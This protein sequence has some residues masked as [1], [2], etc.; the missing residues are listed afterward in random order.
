MVHRG[1]SVVLHG[2]EL[3]AVR[4]EDTLVAT[5]RHK[6]TASAAPM[7]ESLATELKEAADLLASRAARLLGPHWVVAPLDTLA[8]LKATEATQQVERVAG[9][10]ARE[11]SEG[12]E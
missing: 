2:H 12:R 5:I 9:W 11:C 10:G 7:C 4:D 1:L 6:P 8:M 3:S